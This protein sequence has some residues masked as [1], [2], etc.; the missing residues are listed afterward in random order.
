MGVEKDLHLAYTKFSGCL[1]GS[2]RS[3][4]GQAGRGVPNMVAARDS[5]RRDEMAPFTGRQRAVLALAAAD[6]TDKQI[7]RRLGIATSTVRSHWDRAFEN[8]GLHSRVAVVA[9]WLRAESA[10]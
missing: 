10:S 1:K 8:S 3:L 6:C 2:T 4:W 5:R 7:A 9:L